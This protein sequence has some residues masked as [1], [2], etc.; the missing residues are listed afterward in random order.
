MTSSHKHIWTVSKSGQPKEGLHTGMSS[1]DVP[2]DQRWGVAP[3][4]WEG[5]SGV[6]GAGLLRDPRHGNI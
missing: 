5:A 3:Q 4:D 1:S 6:R 2:T